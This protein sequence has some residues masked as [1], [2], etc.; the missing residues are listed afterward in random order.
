MCINKNLIN[1]YYSLVYPYL[2]YNVII[3]GGTFSSRMSQ[4]VI[5]QKNLIRIITGENYCFLTVFGFRSCVYN[6]FSV[7]DSFIFLCCCVCSV[8]AGVLCCSNR[9]CVVVT[10]IV[11]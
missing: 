1:L 2:I 7:R 8:V 9:Y 6:I 4:L 5:L 11:L 3:W 10:G